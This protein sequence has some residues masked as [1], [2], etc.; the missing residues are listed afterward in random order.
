MLK[1]ETAHERLWELSK[2]K[3]IQMPNKNS[4]T[5]SAFDQELEQMQECTFTP[6]INT[7]PRTAKP[8]D[9]DIKGYEET[10]YRLKRAQEMKD[11]KKKVV[12][13]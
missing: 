10:V 11:H 4:V 1:P 6:Q 7:R 8:L 5:S 9:T 3:R 13:R 2:S 12:E